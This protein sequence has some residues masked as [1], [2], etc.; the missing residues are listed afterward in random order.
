MLA[1]RHVV[2]ALSGGVDSAVAALLLRR[3]GYQVT[4]VFMKNWDSLDEHGVCTADKDCEDAYRV[5][6]ILDIPFHQVSYVKE[7]WNDVFSDFLNEYEQGRTPN[8]D[9]MCNKYIKFSCFFRYALDNLGADAVAT[10]HYARTSLEDEE[11]FQQKHIKRPEGLFRNRFEVR[12]ATKLLQAAD[13]LKDQTFFLG[14]VSQDAL[15]RALFPLAGLTKDFVKKIAAENRL[16]H[17]LQRKESMGICFVGKRNFENF[18]LQYLQPRPGRFI[19]IEDNKVLGTHKGWF[20]YTLGQRAKIGGLREP[21]YVA[22]KDGGRGDVFVAPGT[23]HPALFRD[24]LRTSRVHWIAEE[25]PAA[26]VRDKMM[27]CHFRFRHQMALVPCV[28]TLNQDGTVWVTAVRPVRALT[29]GQAS[30]LSSLPCSTRG[31]SAWAAGKSCVWGLPP[32]RSRRARANP[33]WPLRAPVTAQ[34][35][36]PRSK[37]LGADVAEQSLGRAARGSA[38]VV[39]QGAPGW[40]CHPCL[41]QGEPQRDHPHWSSGHKDLLAGGRPG[42]ARPRLGEQNQDRNHQP[43]LRPTEW[44]TGQV[45]PCSRAKAWTLNVS[46]NPLLAGDSSWSSPNWSLAS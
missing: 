25:P 27:E 29:P 28:L 22:E 35:R 4:G 19:S 15:R 16:H 23:D 39:D 10:G 36:V 33:E 44:Q 42:K 37:H 38:A 1:A 18:I 26:L 21:W 20:L 32:T 13:S 30:L 41:G 24:L 43:R 14:Q 17:V 3:R 2:C 34:A 31:T 9:I 8:P 46:W 45:D 7:Y 40:I 6:Q 5:C 11:V 12:N